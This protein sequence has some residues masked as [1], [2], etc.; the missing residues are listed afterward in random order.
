MKID[1]TNKQDAKYNGYADVEAEAPGAYS[2]G[3]EKFASVVLSL[4]GE[5]NQGFRQGRSSGVQAL[6]P[7]EARALAQALL[8]AAEDAEALA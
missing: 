1:F 3:T 2:D 6:S 5:S 4:T 7:A 8:A